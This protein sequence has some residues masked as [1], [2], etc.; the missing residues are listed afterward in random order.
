MLGFS[1]FNC[2]TLAMIISFFVQVE[3][4][5]NLKLFFNCKKQL[6]VTSSFITLAK[7]NY[8]ALSVHIIFSCAV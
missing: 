2:K 7:D 4:R 1:T 6:D 3:V 5:M 8:F